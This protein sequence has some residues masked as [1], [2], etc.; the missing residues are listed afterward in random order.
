MTPTSE[1]LQMKPSRP[2]PMSPIQL[3]IVFLLCKTPSLQAVEFWTTVCEEEIELAHKVREVRG[4]YIYYSDQSWY[5]AGCRI[6]QAAQTGVQAF[7][8]GCL[9]EVI[10][11]LLNLL[12]QQEEDAD[13]GEWNLA[14]SAGTCL[15][16]MAQAVADAVVPAIIPFIE[17]HIKAQDWHQHKAAVM[18]FGS[19]LDGPDPQVLTPL[20][21][22]A[23]PLLIGMMN[24]E[25]LHLELLLHCPPPPPMTLGMAHPCPRLSERGF[26]AP[27]STPTPL[28]CRGTNT[29][30]TPNP[31]SS[32]GPIGGGTSNPSSTTTNPPPTITNPPST[33]SPVGPNPRTLN[34]A[35][36]RLF[37]KSQTI[38]L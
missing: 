3:Q 17:A 25:N 2:R 22:Q 5:S 33:I 23:L 19:I 4:M 6:R 28:A 13:E 11:V 32:A 7:C 21:N 34:A 12:T 35:S 30:V 1:L 20:V 37:Q 8:Q 10:P 38:F 27:S 18:M 9:P 24:D 16:Y 14:M 26:T 36:H 15:N 29:L 31:T